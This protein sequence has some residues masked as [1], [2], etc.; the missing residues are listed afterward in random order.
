MSVALAL[1][2]QTVEQLLPTV[3]SILTSDYVLG[4]SKPW[5][6]V[7]RQRVNG[8]VSSNSKWVTSS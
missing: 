7:V 6:E 2:M 8:K 5:F 4:V 1:V 3:V